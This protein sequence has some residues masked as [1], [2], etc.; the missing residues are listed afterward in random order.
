MKINLSLGTDS[1]KETLAVATNIGSRLHGG[2]V[3]ELI[4]DL[5]GGKTTFT[6]GLAEGAGSKDKVHSPSFT[7]EN[8]YRAA[9]LTI[10]HLDFYRLDDPGIMKDELLEIL[11]DESAV[12]IIE[13]AD[14]VEDLLPENRLII[15]VQTKGESS[16][17]FDFNYPESLSYLLEGL[18]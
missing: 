7:I 8:E 3:I 1:A 10:H 4:S 2:E 18:E 17:Q 11:E 9:H 6:K 15:K 12:V 14:I 16:R 5:G 13:W